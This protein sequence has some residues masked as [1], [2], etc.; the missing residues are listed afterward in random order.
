MMWH[1]PYI[2][3][4]APLRAK[5]SR[6]QN[7]LSKISDTYRG[8]TSISQHNHYFLELLSESMSPIMCAAHRGVEIHYSNLILLR[9]PKSL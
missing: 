1:L 3:K 5:P 4:N 7:K 6:I 8:P 2:H 9:K